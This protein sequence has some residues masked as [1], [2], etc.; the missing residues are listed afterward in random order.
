[1]D[2]FTG[3]ILLVAFL[4]VVGLIVRG[5][6][7]VIMLLVLA[8]AWSAIAGINLNTIQVEVLQGGG[9]KFAAAII[10]I[11][12]GAWFAQILIQ[13]GIA[14][15]I[16]RSAAELAGDRPIVTA[17][18]INTIVALLF[19]SIYGV[20]AAISIGVIA[21]P[22]LQSQ[23]IPARVAAPIYTMAIGAGSFVNLVQF[24]AFAKLFPGLEYKAPYLTYW[25]ICM[26]VYM[27]VAWLMIVINLRRAGVR[28]A[29]AID[30]AE[31]AAPIRRRTPYYTYVVP[32]FPV[33]MVIIF[34]WEIIPTFLLS[35][36]LALLLTWRDRSFQGHVNLFNKAFYDAFPDIANIAALFTICGM[37]IVAGMTPQVSGALKPIFGPILPHT[38][39]GAAVFFGLLGGIGNI[40]RGPLVI[41][42]TGAAVLAL[43]LSS[44]ELSVPYLYSVWL[45]GTVMQASVDPT[46]SWTLWTINQTKITHGQFLKTAL[47]FG[48]LMVAIVSGIAYLMLG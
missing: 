29:A 6:S 44:G 40:Y 8:I 10:I 5:Q 41:I 48:C 2:M 35:I 23:G 39:L 17:I 42:G 3:I 24:G 19:T 12:F 43:L 18:V 13:T 1:M 38:T 21:L 25:A 28:Q 32:L 30:I 37:I 36:V 9:V 11:L 45:G 33:L 20:G 47:P 14:E 46:N 26:V 22:I 7:P 15:S 27:L 16:V 31:S 34:N 4:V